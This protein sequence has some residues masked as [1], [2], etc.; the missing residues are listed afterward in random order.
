[1]LGNQVGRKGW[2][3]A[4]LKKKKLSGAKGWLRE[5]L[6]RRPIRVGWDARDVGEK[7]WEGERERKSPPLSGRERRGWGFPSVRMKKKRRVFPLIGWGFHDVTPP[8]K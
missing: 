2:G 8:K 5:W 4:R 7:G 3:G 1:M 6:E